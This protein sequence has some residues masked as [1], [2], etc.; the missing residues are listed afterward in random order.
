MSAGNQSTGTRILALVLLLLA[1]TAMAQP[2]DLMFDFN[3]SGGPTQSGWVG[4]RSTNNYNSSSQ[5]S[6]PADGLPTGVEAGWQQQTSSERNR[7][8]SDDNMP[9]STAGGDRGV[10]DGIDYTSLLRDYVAVESAAN[11]IVKGL[12]AGLYDVWLIGGDPDWGMQH[13]PYDILV[14]GATYTH[15]GYPSVNGGGNKDMID[16]INT[17]A[18]NPNHSIEWSITVIAPVTLDG[19]QDLTLD[20]TEGND[21]VRLA[22]VRV[23]QVPEP[24]AVT[25]LLIALGFLAVRR[26]W[27]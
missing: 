24:V 23:Q 7:S 27:K 26:W 15:Q 9:G 8:P 18:P 17:L 6:G 22:G 20:T 1:G 2:L 5:I 13:T 16:T 25:L 3:G 4:I 10:L 11:F 19:S 21:E 12:P 14:G